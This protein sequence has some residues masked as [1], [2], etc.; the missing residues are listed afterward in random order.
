MSTLGPKR[1]CGDDSVSLA[2]KSDGDIPE[3]GALW[4]AAGV[5][6][7]EWKKG[8]KYRPQYL[9][10]ALPFFTCWGATFFPGQTK[11]FG[12]SNIYQLSISFGLGR[13]SGDY[14]VKARTRLTKGAGGRTGHG[15]GRPDPE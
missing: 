4:S 2:A 15:A 13:D 5:E 8:K 9:I 7:D 6:E 10:P 12:V 11:Y 3:A 14:S 1:D